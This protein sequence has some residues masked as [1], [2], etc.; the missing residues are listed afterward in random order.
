MIAA[1]ILMMAAAT[2]DGPVDSVAGIRERHDRALIADLR[3]Y[4]DAHPGAVD[5]DAAYLKIFET[6]VE[7]DWFAEAEPLAVRY[8][9]GEPGGAVA[10]MARIVATMA[11]ARAGDFTAARDGFRRL[12]DGL[13]EDRQIAFAADFAQTLAGEAISAGE[14]AVASDVYAALLERFGADPDLRADVARWRARLEL[15]GRPAP[16]FEVTD[17]EGRRLRLE[18]LR[19]RPVLLEF[20]ATWCEPAIADRPALTAAYRAH[21]PNGL[22]ILSVSLDDEAEAARRAARDAGWPWRQVHAPTAGADLVELFRVGQIP[23]TVLIGPDGR[24]ERLDIRGAALGECLGR[25]PAG[26]P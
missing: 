22:E 3:A 23:A 2:C 17:V 7:H 21:G 20:W 1:L 25:R 8:L 11:R 19:G 4:L 14:P 5:R 6:A 10:P 18:D 26:T 13:G 16:D 24:V 9:E 12:M 15:I